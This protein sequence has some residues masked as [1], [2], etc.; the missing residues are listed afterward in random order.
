MSASQKSR[1]Y[2]ERH[3]MSLRDVEVFQVSIKF[4]EFPRLS[5]LRAKGR[6]NG[7]RVGFREWLAVADWP[8]SRLR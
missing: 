7:E 6:K 3:V 1:A 4:P 8:V 5:G 2:N